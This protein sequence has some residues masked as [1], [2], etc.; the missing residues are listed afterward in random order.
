MFGKNAFF[1]FDTEK[2]ANAVLKMLLRFCVEGLLGSSDTL[3][4]SLIQIFPGLFVALSVCLSFDSTGSPQGALTMTPHLFT[5][6]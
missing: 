6:C 1:V 5:V 3:H 2:E 4:N